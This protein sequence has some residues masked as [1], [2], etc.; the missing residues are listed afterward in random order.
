MKR[1]VHHDGPPVPDMT[2]ILNH[3][4][5]EYHERRAM[6][7][8]AL[9]IGADNETGS[10]DLSR[11]ESIISKTH[12][13]FTVIPSIGSW[14]GMNEPSAV[15]ILSDTSESIAATVAT[16]KCELHQ[17]AIGVEELPPITFA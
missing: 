5:A 9:Y 8:T 10:I 14:H 13:G 4:V 15:V 1:P 3:T 12:E 17:D 11:I 16:L 6:K 2:T 7:T